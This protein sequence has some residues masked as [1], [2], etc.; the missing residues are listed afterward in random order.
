MRKLHVG[1]IA[2]CLALAWPAAALGMPTWLAPS[3]FSSTG[4]DELS[5]TAMGAGGGAAVVWMNG[6]GSSPIVQ[7][8]VRMSYGSFG[9][10]M[11][12]SPAGQAAIFPQVAEDAAGDATAV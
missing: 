6:A 12:L 10:A 4:D 2:I 7:A 3:D 11:T 5:D 8:A 1:M 9:S